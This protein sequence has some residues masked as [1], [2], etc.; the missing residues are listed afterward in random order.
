MTVKEAID[1][2]TSRRV[3]EKNMPLQPDHIAKLNEAIDY[4]NELSGLNIQLMTDDNAPFSSK[5]KSFFF[6]NVTNYICMAG[7]PDFAE[8]AGYF[9]E[10]LV[11]ICRSM[12]IDTCWVGGTYDRYRCPCSLQSGECLFCVIAIGYGTPELTLSEKFTHKYLKFKRK[13][14]SE[15]KP[16]NQKESFKAAPDAPLWFMSGIDAAERAP[17]AFDK[18]P[19]LFLWDGHGASA[20]IPDRDRTSVLD[21]GIA[22]L[23]FELGAGGGTWEYGSG[24]HFIKDSL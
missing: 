13:L 9:G 24:S 12:G 7:K 19:V 6:K 1:G 15:I 18:K 22:K 23:H 21:L 5:I 20:F 11:L 2:R 17:S 10:R 8:K 3:F 14:S 16:Q 4:Y